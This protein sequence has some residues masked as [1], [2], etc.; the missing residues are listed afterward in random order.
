MSERG[1]TPFKGF[2]DAEVA[3]ELHQTVDR[4]TPREARSQLAQLNSVHQH[5]TRKDRKLKYHKK[6]T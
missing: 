5:G 3:A 6:I 1:K 2:A 4:P